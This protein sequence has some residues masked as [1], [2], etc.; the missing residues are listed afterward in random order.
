MGEASKTENKRTLAVWVG[1]VLTVAWLVAIGLI[2]GRPAACEG[3]ESVP[4]WAVWDWFG[5]CRDTNEIGDFLAGASAPIAFL[6]LVVAVFVQSHEL[7]EQRRELALTRKEYEENRKTAEATR[8]EIAAQAEQARRSAEFMEKQTEILEAQRAREERVNIEETFQA[9]LDVMIDHIEGH[10]NGASWS[11]NNLG[12]YLFEVKH[13]ELGNATRLIKLLSA[14]LHE[15]ADEIEHDGVPG[16]VGISTSRALVI[17]G[18][19]VASLQR[20]A[21][22]GPSSLKSRVR[23]LDLFTL[24]TGLRRV[25]DGFNVK[26]ELK[27]FLGSGDLEFPEF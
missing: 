20:I 12:S 5:S 19:M 6:W 17:L 9:E 26:G 3:F 13:D 18:E 23:S 7:Q 8:V 21:D 4:M 10:L 2:V 14:S 25:L 24:E 27:Y 15:I 22:G 1:I 16:Q 11:R